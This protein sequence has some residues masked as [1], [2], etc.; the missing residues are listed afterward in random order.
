MILT[1]R[2]NLLPTILEVFKKGEKRVIEKRKKKFYLF[3]SNNLCISTTKVSARKYSITWIKKQIKKGDIIL[4]NDEIVDKIGVSEGEFYF[5]RAGKVVY[6]GREKPFYLYDFGRIPYE[7]FRRNVWTLSIRGKFV[8]RIISGH[9]VF[10]LR[11]EI[12]KDLKEGDF[13]FVYRVGR[14]F[15]GYFEISEIKKVKV[16]KIWEEYR[17]LIGISSKDFRRYFK[18]YEF[19]YMIGIKR[20]YKFKEIKRIKNFRVPSNFYLISERPSLIEELLS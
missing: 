1:E 20:F 16:S 18:G 12:P 4:F 9:K 8:D 13:V 14:G 15:Q 6:V 10:E 11:K 7:F 3:W 5:H 19:G 17:H 2:K